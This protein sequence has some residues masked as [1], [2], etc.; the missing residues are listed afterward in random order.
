VGRE[1]TLWE[2]ENVLL[3]WY[4]QAWA[5]GVPVNSS[6][7]H[8]EVKHI[9]DTLKIDSFAASNRSVGSKIIMA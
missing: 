9:A 7:L 6:I 8:G 1:C 5:L 3:A 4:L 2:L